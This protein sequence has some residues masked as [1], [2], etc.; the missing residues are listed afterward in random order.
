[1]T[2]KHQKNQPKVLRHGWR[3]ARQRESPFVNLSSGRHMG[4]A[5]NFN[6]H[7]V[8]EFGKEMAPYLNSRNNDKPSW[9]SG[10]SRVGVD[11][12]CPSPVTSSL[13]PSENKS[14]W[15]RLLGLLTRTTVWG[16]VQPRIGQLCIIMTGVAGQDEGQM[17]IVTSQTKVMVEVTLASKTGKGTITKTKQPRSLVLLEPG[18][19]LVQD[20]DGSVW[21]RAVKP[22]SK[23]RTGS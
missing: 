14:R 15:K 6:S 3:E 21:V 19:V 11:D 1:M 8:H 18:L 13:G 22:Q 16:N 12:R 4:R 17:G 20:S 9:D 2:G 7:F 5:N 10:N 23:E